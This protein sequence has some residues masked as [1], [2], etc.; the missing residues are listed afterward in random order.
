VKQGQPP[1][2]PHLRQERQADQV[3][4]SRPA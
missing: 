4:D 1:A 3:G 2:V